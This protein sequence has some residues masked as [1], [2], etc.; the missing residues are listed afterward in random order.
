MGRNEDRREQGESAAAVGP[1]LHSSPPVPS[2]G[3]LTKPEAA[4]QAKC[5]LKQ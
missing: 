3:G 5:I 1:V 2:R 4:V